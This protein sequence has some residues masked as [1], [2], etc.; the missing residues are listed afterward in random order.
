ML[1]TSIFC[2]EPVLVSCRSKL[3]G[4]TRRN[5]YCKSTFACCLISATKAKYFWRKG[6]QE[7]P[8]IMGSSSLLFLGLG[9]IAYGV[10]YYLTHDMTPKYYV[11]KPRSKY[12]INSSCFCLIINIILHYDCVIVMQSGISVDKQNCW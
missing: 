2:E 9:M 6:W 1:K 4:N 12:A 8:V 10:N 3:L 5:N 7:I 11:N